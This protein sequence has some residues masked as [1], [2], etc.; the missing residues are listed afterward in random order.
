MPRRPVRI[1][2]CSGA[3]PDQGD[4]MLHQATAGPVDVITGDYLAEAN[5]A[6]YAEAYSRGEHPG[7][8]STAWDGLQLSLGAI[9]E[10]RIKVI[11]NGG[12]LNPKGLA[13]KTDAL[14]RQ[15]GFHLRVAW[16]EGDD[17]TFKPRIYS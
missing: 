8:V 11:I 15:K 12:G 5:L 3:I 7:W 9:H 10:H 16:V 6:Q 4:F 14:V 13:E 17:L 2:N 1:A